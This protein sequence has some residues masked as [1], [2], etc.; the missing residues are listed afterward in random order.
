MSGNYYYFRYLLTGIFFKT[1][2]DLAG[3][4]TVPQRT[5][6]IACVSFLQA[7]CF[8]CDSVENVK[9]WILSQKV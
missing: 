1:C 8:S 4:P 5:F 3:N 7:G 6:G 2:Q 9:H